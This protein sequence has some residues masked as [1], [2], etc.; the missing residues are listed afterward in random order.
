MV[1]PSE[2]DVV[3]IGGGIAGLA[4]AYTLRDEDVVVLEREPSVGGRT[5]SEQVDGLW[6]NY[7]AQMITSE[8][9]TVV[10]LASDVGC[11][12]LSVQWAHVLERARLAFQGMRVGG[13]AAAQLQ[14]VIRRLEAEQADPRPLTDPSIDATSFGAWLGNVDPSVRAFWEDWSQG[15][16]NASVDEISLYAALSLWGDQRVSPWRSASAEIPRHAYGDCVVAGGTGELGRALGAALGD[17]VLTNTKVTELRPRRGGYTILARRDGAETELHARRVIC[18]LPAPLVLDIAGWL[19]AAK[20]DALGSVSYGRFIVTPIWVSRDGE[21]PRWRAAEPHRP[22]QTYA[23]RAFPLRTPG[24]PDRDGACYQSWVNDHAARAIWDD[25]DESIRS[26][27]ASAFLRRFPAYEDR[28]ARIGVKR[29]HYGLPKLSPGRMQAMSEITA[30]IGDVHF[31][32]DYTGIANLEGAATSGI[33]AARAI[34]ETRV[35]VR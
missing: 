19:P 15:L 28:I 1:S 5:Y 12:L 23:L 16:A 6:G 24:D 17:R 14:E 7:G 30:P 35:G 25:S 22:E 18:A 4:A 33:R 13:D 29:W 8:R 27:V 34:L 21:P 3:V 9:V 31:C 11:E 26:G 20:R 2:T 32:G 10:S